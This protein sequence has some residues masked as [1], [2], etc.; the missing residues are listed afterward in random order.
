MKQLYEIKR[1]LSLLLLIG[2]AILCMGFIFINCGKGPQSKIINSD[3]GQFAVDCGAAPAGSQGKLGCVIYFNSKELLNRQGTEVTVEAWVKRK[4]DDLTGF[5]FDHR[6]A[7][8]VAM[9]IKDNE[10]KFAIRRLVNATSSDFVVESNVTLSAN[11]WYHIAGVLVNAVHSHPLSSS[12]TTT[13]MAETPHMDIYVDGEFKNC[14]STG[15][16]SMA[17]LTCNP[18]SLGTGQ[19]AGDSLAIGGPLAVGICNSGDFPC[20]DVTSESLN[21]IIDEVRYYTTARTHTLIQSCMNTELGLDGNCSRNSIT[22]GA[23]MRFNEGK[24]AAPADW[25]G[26]GPGSKE[27]NGFLVTETGRF[28][29]GGWVSGAPITRKD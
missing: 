5:V 14:A 4:T 19:C 9:W 7:E 16:R 1:K 22:L 13:V 20:T 18:E 3:S 28:W 23:Y 21:G 26:L 11:T 17:T 24:G 29:D 27:N 6:T 8:G 15:S 10:P 2:I 12:C 25:T